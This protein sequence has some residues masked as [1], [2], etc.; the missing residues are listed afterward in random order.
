M[1]HQERPS[2]SLGCA[3]RPLGLDWTRS[4][5]PRNSKAGGQPGP[6]SSAVDAGLSNRPFDSSSA[7][8]FRPFRAG[9]AGSEPSIFGLGEVIYTCVRF[10]A[11]ILLQECK[12]L[13]ASQNVSRPAQAPRLFQT[14][15]QR[16]RILGNSQEKVR[17]CPSQS[18]NPYSVSHSRGP[19]NQL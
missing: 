14:L 15:V 2:R 4:I 19:A 18:R 6:E 1:S 7:R 13:S 5:P 11:I 12:P 8:G 17:P 9:L 10:P 16:H 3:H